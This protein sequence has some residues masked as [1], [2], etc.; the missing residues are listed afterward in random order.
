MLTL[1]TARFFG[2]AEDVALDPACAV[3][4]V[5]TASLIVD[6]LP[7]MDD[8]RL[9]RGRTANHLVFGEH[10]ATL[11]AIELLN[12]A[13]GTVACAKGIPSD[14]RARLGEC[15]S[16]SIGL[17]GLV[18]GQLLDLQSA[19]R[20]PDREEVVDVYGRKTGALLSVSI[21]I[22]ARVAGAEAPVLHQ[23]NEF[24]SKLGL[25]FQI[26][27]DLYDRFGVSEAIG[28]DVGQDAAKTTLLSHLSAEEA[29]E[30][31]ERLMAAGREQLAPLGSAGEQL[32]GLACSLLEE[33]TEFAGRVAQNGT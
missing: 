7:C 18:G 14:V 32:A 8:A 28:K 10:V 12:R 33:A 15:L 27:D 13:F 16:L 22:G 23:L 29:C 31:V 26:L 25:A 30:D 11:A 21:E 4:M 24:S 6:D 2:A 20:R 5:H 17:E 9:R 1:A 3:E 19:G